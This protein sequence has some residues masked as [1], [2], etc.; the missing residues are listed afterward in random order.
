MSVHLSDRTQRSRQSLSVKWLYTVPLT[1]ALF[2]ALV[3]GISAL[4]T[5][6]KH[7]LI[8]TTFS[9]PMLALFINDWRKL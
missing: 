7:G 1:I 4:A 2:L 3:Y 5:G 6:G 9:L 8:I